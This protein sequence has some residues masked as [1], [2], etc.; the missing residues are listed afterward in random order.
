MDTVTILGLLS[1]L[2]ITANI[3]WVGVSI[4]LFAI[5]ASTPVLKVEQAKC[6]L[7]VARCYINPAIILSFALG[8]ALAI[9][10]QA[11][12]MPWLNI[13][14]TL[15]II[16]AGLHGLLVGQLKRAAKED[17]FTPPKW[18][19]FIAPVITLLTLGIVVLVSLKP[20]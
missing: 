11:F 7:G 20:L 8:V 9:Q 12:K 3:V 13:K 15:A 4:G 16:L 6:L 10:T 18:L 1:A 14:M 2:H 5:I 17:N 19:G